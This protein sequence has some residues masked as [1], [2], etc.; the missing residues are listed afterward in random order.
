MLKVALGDHNAALDDLYLYLETNPEDADAYYILGKAYLGLEDYP[1][2]VDSLTRAV[3]LNPGDAPAYYSRAEAYAALNENELAVVDIN[4]AIELGL[5]G[6]YLTAA[7][8]LL[9][10]ILTASP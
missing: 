4:K 10:S 7:R 6:E 8:N 9:R 1:R 5:S 2:A 3:S